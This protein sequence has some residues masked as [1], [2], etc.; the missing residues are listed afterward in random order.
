MSDNQDS[1]TPFGGAIL[2]ILGV[3]IGVALLQ[4]GSSDE[5]SGYSG[6]KST[7]TREDTPRRTLPTRTQGSAV[8]DATDEV[9][10][11]ELAGI[12]A[13]VAQKPD[14]A[15]DLR[16]GLLDF[17][18]PVEPAS[19][20]G[21]GRLRFVTWPGPGEFALP[22][23]PF[24]L[25]PSRPKVSL[26]DGRI[27]FAFKVW[28][29]DVSEHHIVHEADLLVPGFEPTRVRLLG[30]GPEGPGRCLGGAIQLQVGG[31]GVVGTV[32]THR[33][34]PISGAVVVG[35]GERALTDGDGSYFLMPTD[36]GACTVVA[37]AAP[38]S[39]SS[40]EP[41]TIEPAADRDTVVDF[42]I[43]TPSV[44]DGTCQRE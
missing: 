39:M 27:R 30:P 25:R 22:G 20:T 3:A 36:E 6:V 40:A 23:D 31:H 13:E 35:C 9:V 43:F 26:A 32:T 16:R 24:M 28:E 21:Q 8:P 41:V 17:D 19:A 5:G 37:R 29:K 1:G 33:G 4:A 42:R 18:C 14:S 15:D 44:R 11:E 7:A 2:A 34:V 10:D 38:G 12:P